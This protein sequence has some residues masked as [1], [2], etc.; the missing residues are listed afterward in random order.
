MAEMAGLSA[1]TM[2]WA[3]T[4]VPQAFKKF[5]TICQLM[6]DGPLAEKSEAVKVKYLLLWSGEEGIDVSST[7]DLTDNESNTLSVYW[8]RFGKYV[9]PKCNFRIA[10]FKLRSMKQDN[11]ESVDAYMK[12]VRILARECKYTDTNEHML[13]TLIFGTNSEHVQSKLIQRDETL[14]LD[15]A[16][17]IARTEEATKQQLQSLK[18]ESNIHAMSNR[19]P[20]ATRKP[21]HNASNYGTTHD[22]KSTQNQRYSSKPQQCDTAHCSHCG[23]RCGRF[24]TNAIEECAAYGSTCRGC[25]KANHWIKMCMTGAKDARTRWPTRPVMAKKQ[26]IHAWTGKL[27]WQVYPSPSYSFSATQ[28]CVQ[29]GRSL[30]LGTRTRCSIFNLEEGYL[31]K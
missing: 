13:D 3:S 14:S 20:H 22:G 4:D 7:W 30:R 18:A 8:D 15:E 16:I 2:D 1:L 11:G 19:R 29:D 26:G 6:F 25:G 31:L 24:Y 17:D 9:A 27:P 28:R 21:W 10:R 12:T 5:K 23:R